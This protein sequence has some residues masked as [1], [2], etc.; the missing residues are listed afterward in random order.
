MKRTPLRRVSAKRARELADYVPWR[1]RVM[2]LRMNCEARKHPE[3]AEYLAVTCWGPHD[4]HH[5]L[6]IGKGG[7]RMDETNVLRLCRAH[8]DWAHDNP[9]L[10]KKW[11]LLR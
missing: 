1:V 4:L 7:R 10:A 8:H 2:R 5:V 11:G 6:P 3:A 9:H